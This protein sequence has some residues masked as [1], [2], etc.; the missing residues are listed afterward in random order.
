MAAF[1]RF[2]STLRGILNYDE[3]SHSPTT[4][5]TALTYV[6]TSADF[7]ISMMGRITTRYKKLCSNTGE[8]EYHEQSPN[9]SK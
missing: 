8:E 6:A 3:I 4:I 9:W 5:L 2:L 7:C 1:D